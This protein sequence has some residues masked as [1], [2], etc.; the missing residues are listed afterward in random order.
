M[1]E[2]VTVK[3]VGSTLVAVFNK[4]EP[5]LVWNFDL[6]KNGQFSLSLQGEDKKWQIGVTSLKG[7][8]NPIACFPRHEDALEAFTLVQKILMKGHRS[9]WTVQ[10]L[11]SQAF[12]SAVVVMFMFGML[13]G[14]L[15]YERMKIASH[16][17]KAS[18]NGHSMEMENGI[19][20]PADEVLKPPQ[21]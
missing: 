14:F 15:H 4:A 5:P 21:E 9:S 3:Y 18:A 12:V 8:F 11:L 20:L 1:T 17:I 10:G 6:D 13:V 19:P 16:M 2:S 7:E